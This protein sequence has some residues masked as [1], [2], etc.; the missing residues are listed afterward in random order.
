MTPST[1]IAGSL[2]GLLFLSALLWAFFLL[3]GLRWARVQKVTLGRV[4]LATV[5]TYVLHVTVTVGLRLALQR[6]LGTTLAFLSLDLIAAALIPCLVIK[7]V[8]GIELAR[9][10]QAWTP[11]LIPG[12]AVLCVLLFVIRPFLYEAYVCPT[13]S[14]APTLL[15]NHWRDTCPECG[16]SNYCTPAEP[17]PWGMEERLRICANFHVSENANPGQQVH[18]GDRFMVLKTLE[19]QRWD[20]VVFRLP[21]NPDVNYVKRLVGL[22][23]EEIVIKAGAVWADGRKLT[24]PKAIR[25]IEYVT[26]DP[27]GFGLGLWGSPERPAVLGNDEYFVLGDFSRQARDSRYWEQ[28][29]PGHPSYAV[30]ESNMIGVVT[31]IYWPP[32]R[33][34]AFR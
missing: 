18:G 30:P 19:L 6:T 4:T 20:L 22:P 34:R 29:A 24:P 2:L 32:E 1:M 13:N 21:E 31:H 5:L 33:W 10:A 25:G 12:A 16:E 8:F 27:L 15:G 9:A 17:A 26:Q 3:L 28:G 14:M 11:T 7:I 23:G